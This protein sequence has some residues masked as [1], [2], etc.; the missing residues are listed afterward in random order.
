MA[1]S[2]NS[3]V[4]ALID[5]GLQPAAARVVANALANAS[6]PQFSQ[7]RDLS[8][9]TPATALRLIGPDDR[10]YR[11]TNLDYSS[12]EPYERRLRGNPGQFAAD[13]SDHPYKD[14]QPVVPVPPL[15]KASITGGE[16]VAVD[17]SVKDG[18]PLATIGLK[19]NSRAGTHLRTNPA[20]NSLDAV[21]LEFSSPQGL[22]TADV[23][24][25]GDA[26]SVELAVR[27]LRKLTALQSDGTS[28]GIFAWT[29]TTVPSATIF[30]PWI[31]QNVLSKSTAADVLAALGIYTSGTWTPAI[32]VTGTPT[33]I[34]QPSIT[35]NT[36]LTVG[37]WA[38]LGQLVYVTGR[39]SLSTFAAGSGGSAVVIS[40]LPFTVLSGQGGY[41]AGVVAYKLNWVTNGPEHVYAEA[42]SN[43]LSMSYHVATGIGIV[44]PA[45]L[46]AGSDMI[47]SC[48][49]WATS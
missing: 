49:Y 20:T 2:S 32:T 42:A 23:T 21:P 18:A 19:L 41:A 14:A 3:L 1:G 35:Y 37:R 8:D 40:G 22:V 27:G 28:R 7:S 43:V 12:E 39:L 31:Q 44:A 24:E 15:S 38:K 16:Y 47:F 10:R 46:A 30:T 48:L 9:Q 4:Q 34:V 13:T 29:D 45:N 25:L 17:N 26:T 11:F 33:P 5:G 6:T 36:S